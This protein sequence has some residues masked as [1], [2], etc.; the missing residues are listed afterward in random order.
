M[1]VCLEEGP[2]LLWST[3]FVSHRGQLE[4]GFL[5]DW[6]QQEMVVAEE[7]VCVSEH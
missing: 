7:A 4:S 3:G 1:C 6:W 5:P 2:G